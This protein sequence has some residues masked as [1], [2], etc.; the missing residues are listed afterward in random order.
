MSQRLSRIVVLLT[1]PLFLSSMIVTSWADDINPGVFPINSKLYGSTYGEWSAKW[2]QWAISI[3]T[4]ESPMLDG[5]G[6]K[7]TKSQTNPNVFFLFGAGGG[8]A[9][10]TCTIPAG[11]AI[12]I[13]ILAVECSYAEFPQL[14]AE[15]D[16][17]KC[18]KDDQDTVLSVDLT[19]DGVNFR[20][21]K[22]KYR[23]HSN[24]FNVTFPENNIFGVEPP[25]SSQ[26]VSDGFF[27]LLEPP[28]KGKHE[29]HFKGEQGSY[30]V[31]SPQH[32]ADDVKYNII[33][34]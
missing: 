18:A 33:V 2:W 31:T 27:I 7:C 24:L 4:A 22:E 25:R 32:Y 23:T 21:L 1:M 10:C 3:P 8:Q 19:V 28:T 5:T 12:M 11:K 17:H 20:D 13:P 6:E 26:A 34:K 30:T 16:L 15:A 14:K 29:I 9:E